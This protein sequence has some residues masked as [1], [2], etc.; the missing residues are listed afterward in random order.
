MEK[1]DVRIKLNLTQ[2]EYDTFKAKA[3]EMELSMSA[4]CVEAINASMGKLK[5]L[6]PKHITVE[7][8]DIFTD[9]IT[10]CLN[11][12]GNKTAKLDRLLFT[13]SM[14]GNVASYELERLNTLVQ[15]LKAEEKEFNNN[16]VN[17]YD[18]RLKMKKEICRDIRKAVKKKL[19]E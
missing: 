12:V 19:E 11:K 14:K 5:K 8:V 7:P 16:M 13:L 3:D 15:E 4:F 6:E 1:R 18:E 17:V 2:E 9:D 10:E